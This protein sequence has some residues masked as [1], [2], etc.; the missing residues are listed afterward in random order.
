MDRYI[1]KDTV[2]AYM[3]DTC[4]WCKNA[5]AEFDGLQPDCEQCPLHRLK[6]KL[7]FVLDANVRPIAH[8]Q[9]NGEADGYADGDPVYD[10][11]SCSCCGMYFDEWDEMPDW[12][13]C[14]N[15]GA[16]MK[17]KYKCT[18]IRGDNNAGL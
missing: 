9:W 7:K 18:D 5:V 6:E 15:C 12:K 14:P 17:N 3:T 13:Y 4:K 11:W 1:S 16:Q 10:I 8:G 2:G